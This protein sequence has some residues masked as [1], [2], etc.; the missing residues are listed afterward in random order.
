MP[1]LSV[2]VMVAP[3]SVVESGNIVVLVV[4]AASPL[5]NP[6]AM[7]SGATIGVQLPADA[8]AKLVL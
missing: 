6:A 5:P 3:P 7:E 2:I 8:V 1:V 4:E